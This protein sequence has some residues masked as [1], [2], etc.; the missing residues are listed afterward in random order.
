M[1]VRRCVSYKVVDLVYGSACR[2]GL[3]AGMQKLTQTVAVTL[4]PRV[5]TTQGRQVAIDDELGKPKLTKDGVTVAKHI[6]LPDALHE[7]GAKLLKN[8]ANE[9]NRYA[10]DG[11]TTTSILTTAIVKL[12]LE[13]ARRGVPL[14]QLKAGIDLG[15][16]LAKA[17][18]L[19][20]KVP[21][22]RDA[23]LMSVARVATNFDEHTSALVKDAVI[24]AGRQ[25][26]IQIEEGRLP[27]NALHVSPS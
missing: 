13:A 25:G 3:F 11:T 22:T 20:R 4:G 7:L 15:G 12:G 9:A 26:I 14:L 1:R 17:Y 6:E 24:A 18:I 23:D 19:D 27:E 21:V 2:E 16:R 10:G 5:K 8:S